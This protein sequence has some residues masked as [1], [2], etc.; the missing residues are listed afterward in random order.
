MPRN[1]VVTY[2]LKTLRRIPDDVVLAV[3]TRDLDLENPQRCLCGWVIREQL[4]AMNG[5]AAEKKKAGIPSSEWGDF[6][7]VEHA[8]ELFG[9]TYKAW[10]DIF[11]GVVRDWHAP[12]IEEAFTLRVMEAV[13]AR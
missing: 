11:I 6:D 8:V 7:V 2:Y 12:L 10:D 9:G 4:A 1:P 13:D 3:A 5:V